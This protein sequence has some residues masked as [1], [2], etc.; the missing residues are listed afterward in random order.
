MFKIYTTQF[1]GV[2]FRWVCEGETMDKRAARATVRTLRAGG[3]NVMV[4]RDG[5][6]LNWKF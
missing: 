3:R 6:K 1:D 5:K 4:E 2:T